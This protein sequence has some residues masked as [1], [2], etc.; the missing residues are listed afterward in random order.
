[1]DEEDKLNTL[2]VLDQ[3]T[4]IK[5]PRI[6]AHSPPRDL[7]LDRMQHLV[8]D[9]PRAMHAEKFVTARGDRRQHCSEMVS[10]MLKPGI[11]GLTESSHC[12]DSV[13]ILF[14]QA[15]MFLAT[16]LS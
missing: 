16:V 12:T 2:G 11:G 10:A 14:D 15:R 7:A 8:M 1:M 3:R 9:F 5:S 6:S 13:A 4:N